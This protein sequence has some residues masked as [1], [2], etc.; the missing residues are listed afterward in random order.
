[1]LSIEGPRV[2]QIGNA[3][4][5]E[6]PYQ[7][8]V[9]FEVLRVWKG[10]RSAEITVA[11]TESDCRYGFQVGKEYLVWANDSGG[12]LLTSTCSPNV[13]FG[14]AGQ[15]RATRQLAFL[16]SWPGPAPLPMVA[17]PTLAAMAA[18]VRVWTRVV[19]GAGGRPV[20][21]LWTLVGLGGTMMAAP[22]LYVFLTIN[23]LP[24]ILGI[25]AET[26][27]LWAVTL[28]IAA[29]GGG[30]LLAGAGLRP[31]GS[32]RRGFVFALALYILIGVG[33]TASVNLYLGEYDHLLS[34]P[35]QLAVPLWSWQVTMA[36]SSGRFGLGP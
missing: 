20:S 28:S 26:P 36:I 9:R 7:S 8:E 24:R 3:A 25:V 19:R 33:W 15:E 1:M 34:Y 14:P 4:R 30:W 18:A 12:R 21:P 35:H 23:A 17:I 31:A 29:I 27:P 6:P 5:M 10:V 2:T 16:D 13:V 22:A 32:L 11:D